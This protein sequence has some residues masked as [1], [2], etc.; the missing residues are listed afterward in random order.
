M[1]R[2]H[3]NSSLVVRGTGRGLGAIISGFLWWSLIDLYLSLVLQGFI[4]VVTAVIT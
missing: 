1:G 4:E 2:E 3:F